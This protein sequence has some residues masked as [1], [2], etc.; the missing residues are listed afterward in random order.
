MS[1]VPSKIAFEQKYSDCSGVEFAVRLDG[2]EIEFQSIN[3]VNFPIEELPWLI[4]SL[5]AIRALISPEGKMK[6]G[7]SD[8]QG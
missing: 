5:E 2:R 6:G 1:I 3:A 8:G 7:E 4:E